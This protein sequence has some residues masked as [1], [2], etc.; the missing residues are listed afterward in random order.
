MASYRSSLEFKLLPS[1]IGMFLPFLALFAEVE[2]DGLNWPKEPVHI[3]EPIVMPYDVNGV[4]LRTSETVFEGAKQSETIAKQGN[5]KLALQYLYWAIERKPETYGYGE[6]ATYFALS[7]APNTAIHW[8]QR[9]AWAEG[10]EPG[11]VE[12]EPIFNAVVADAR[13]PKIREFLIES[14]QAWLQSRHHTDILILPKDYKTGTQLPFVLLMHG[15][16][17]TPERM[18]PRADLKPSAQALADQFQIALLFISGT[19]PMAKYSFGWTNDLDA[20]YIHVMQALDRVKDRAT[21]KN[22]R[23]IHV[24]FSRGGQVGIELAVR[25]TNQF[26]ASCVFCPGTVAGCRLDQVHP[27]PNL[28]GKHYLILNGAGEDA[29]CH[30][31]ADQNVQFVKQCG[32]KVQYVDVPNLGHSM[33]SNWTEMLQSWLAKVLATP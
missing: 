21:P 31:V 16:G 3:K 1:M 23:L 28:A 17:G 7:N 18:I 26:L 30:Q 24:G 10:V 29:L 12:K 2:I 9:A 19:Q 20:D 4:D 14:R 32:A 33:P 25:H 8:L 11:L 27:K 13:W 22:D 6:L 15:Q 5:V